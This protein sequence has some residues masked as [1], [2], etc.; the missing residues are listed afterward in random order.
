MIRSGGGAAAGARI[1]SGPAKRMPHQKS[2]PAPGSHP[3]SSVCRER[4]AA[5]LASYV[6]CRGAWVG[7]SLILAAEGGSHPINHHLL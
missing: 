2:V 7:G 6:K 3:C 4:T 1:L 5:A